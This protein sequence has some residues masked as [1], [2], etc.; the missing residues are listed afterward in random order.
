MVTL[1]RL[2][3]VAIQQEAAQV[4]VRLAH[5]EYPVR[6]RRRPLLRLTNSL[7]IS[8]SSSSSSPLIVAPSYFPIR[9]APS[10]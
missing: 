9:V 5:H 8:L 7:Y 2:R 6:A 3:S 1:F 10:A 4:V